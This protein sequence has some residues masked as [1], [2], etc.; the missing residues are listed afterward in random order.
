MK[1][2]DQ[3]LLGGLFHELPLN[4]EVDEIVSL[5]DQL[6]MPSYCVQK[7]IVYYDTIIYVYFTN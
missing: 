1:T 3:H 7:T 5:Q 4:V 2:T 6:L